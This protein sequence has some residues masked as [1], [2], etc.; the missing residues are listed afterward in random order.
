MPR[1]GA[2]KYPWSCG[3]LRDT[4]GPIRS[5]KCYE[6]ELTATKLKLA[7]AEAKLADA[8]AD[9]E[10]WQKQADDRLNDAVEFGRRAEKAEARVKELEREL[11]GALASV[12]FIRCTKH[13]KVPIINQKAFHGG[14][15]G[16]C[17]QERVKELEGLKTYTTG[18]EVE[19][20]SK[21]TVFIPG[22]RLVI[23][24]MTTLGDAMPRKDAAPSTDNKQ[25]NE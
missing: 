12:V 18:D 22:S 20:V 21:I 10:S 23:G 25:T 11:D 7:A 24:C 16:A 2:G 3:T 6:R 19:T 5:S 1:R 8:K 15:C 13:A 9:A 17:I 14:E 4:V